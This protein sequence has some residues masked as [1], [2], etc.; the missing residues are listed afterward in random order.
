MP[1]RQNR[2]IGACNPIKLKE[3]L[4][5]GKPVVSTPFAELRKYR[6]VV[7]E[8]D[9]PQKF[10]NCIKRAFSEDSP[11]L[12]AKRRQKVARVSWD[13]KAKL[14]WDK[15]FGVDDGFKKTD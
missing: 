9:A 3:Y 10:A 6:D 15:L 4:A 11:E 8:A 12:A 13:S 7:Y 1:W 14:V 2:W 5:L